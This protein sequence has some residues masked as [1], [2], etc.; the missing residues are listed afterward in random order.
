[1]QATSPS[2]A[3]ILLVLPCC[4]GC[5]SIG[6]PP[7]I[8]EVAG[9]YIGQMNDG[10]ETYCR[11]ELRPDGTGLCAWSSSWNTIPNLYKVTDWRLNK[12]DIRIDLHQC[13]DRVTPQPIELSGR[14]YGSSLKLEA[15]IL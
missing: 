14:A 12:Y 4:A 7:T 2:T 15:R 8:K 10:P 5:P 3:L 1:M 13:D 11:L 9:V 6:V